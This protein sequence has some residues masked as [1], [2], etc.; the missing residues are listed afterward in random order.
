LPGRGMAPRTYRMSGCKEAPVFHPTL[1]EFADPLRYIA[2]IRAVAEPC[3]LCRIVPP[4]GFVVPFNQDRASF[5][6]KTRVQTVTELQLRVAKGKHRSW[7]VEYVEFMQT[8]EHQTVTRWPVFGGRKLDLRVLYESVVASHGGFDLAC[9]GK[10]WRTIA[11]GLEG[12]DA[13]ASDASALKQLYQKWLLPFET[14]KKRTATLSPASKAKEAAST[15]KEKEEERR[16]EKA[17]AAAAVERASAMEQPSEKEEDL[18]EALFELG[19]VAEPPPKRLK[20]EMVRARGRSRDPRDFLFL[21]F[22]VF[23]IVTTRR[24][25]AFPATA[26]GARRVRGR[27]RPVAS[28]RVSRNIAPRPPISFEPRFRHPR[29]PRASSRAVSFSDSLADQLPLFFH[30]LP[31]SSS[32]NRAQGLEEV[33]QQLE[34]FGCQNCGG[35]A[36]EDSMILCDGCDFGYVRSLMTTAAEGNLRGAPSSIRGRF[37]ATRDFWRFGKNP[38]E[39]RKK[40]TDIHPTLFPF[41]PHSKGTTRTASPL[42]S[43]QSPLGTGSAPTASPSRPTPMTWGSTPARRSPWMSLKRRALSSTKGSL[44]KTETPPRAATKSRRFP[45]SR[46]TSGAW[47]RKGRAAAVTGTPLMCTTALTLTRRRTAARFRE[48]GM[49]I[50]APTAGTT[51]T[52]PRFALGT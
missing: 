2:S 40:E 25:V 49:S 43:H 20:L 31:P 52:P 19:N 32:S 18:L 46:N 35:S 14:H 33:A 15:K 42:P 47:S 1:A 30:H 26:E 37:S 45:K 38:K 3:G 29:P 28:T 34:A 51:Q 21:L 22:L 16:R 12:T 27:D 24:L 39:K 7:R 36:H 4:D 41:P 17:S 8:H 6:F 13:S 11:S 10:L 48:R 9:R 44:P 23:A 5:T 50:T